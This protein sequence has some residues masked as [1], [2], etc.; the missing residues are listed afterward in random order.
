MILA[1]LSGG[2]GR[3]I[4]A[5]VEGKALRAELEGKV[6]ALL[7]SYRAWDAANHNGIGLSDAKTSGGL[8][9]GES[10]FLRSYM[11][12]YQVTRDTYWLDKTIDHFDRMIGNLADPDGDGY[13]AWS[14]T[15]YSVG[16]VDAEPVGDVG[17][18]TIEPAHQ[19]PYVKRGGELVTGHEYRIEFTADDRLRVLGLTDGKDLAAPAY[20]DPTVIEAIPGAKLTLKG[21]GKGGAAFRVTTHAPEPCEYQVHDGMVTYPIAQFIE[22]AFADEKL[23]AKYRAKADEYASLLWKHFLEKWESTWVDLPD[24]AGLYKFTKNPT[25]RFPDY[26]LP[27]NQ[28][29][30]LARTWLVLQAIPGLEHRDEYRDRAEKMAQ[31]LKQNL[32]LAGEAY[33]WNYWDPLPAEEGV[34]RYVEDSSHATID[35]GFAV[36]A[37]QRGLVFTDEDLQRFAATYTQVMWNGSLD[38]P[39]IGDRV[40]TDKGD[41]RMWSE[42]IMLGRASE[43]V[44]NLAAALYVAQGRPVSMAPQLASLYDTVVG[45]GEADLK[46]YADASAALEQALATKGLPNAGFEIGAPGAGPFGWT[47][48]TWGPDEGGSAEWVDDAH[49]GKHA[50]ALIGKGDK[51]NV[52]AQ[53][54]RNLPGRA[55]QTVTVSVWYKTSDAAR[56]CFSVLGFDAKG[57]RAQYDTSPVLEA[58]AEWKQGTWSVVLAEG[59]AELSLLLRNHGVGTV[60]YDDVAVKVD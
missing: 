36:E 11:L 41:G 40:D 44:C 8:G 23:P 17:G 14:D 54:V 58:T 3:A 53:P 59:V 28:Y 33:V 19:K 27:H 48:T 51:V 47:L 34:R 50:V 5:E 1:V 49:E 31:Y 57:E 2:G 10:S 12:C 26:S 29:L 52:L 42:W 56:P 18:L 20:A 4:G 37:A 7:A 55:G 22:V 60:H 15:D 24:G 43:A 9:W 21:P 16:L 13:L 45:V 30:A 38:D 25:Q 46:A 39:R 6:G 32:K 35:I